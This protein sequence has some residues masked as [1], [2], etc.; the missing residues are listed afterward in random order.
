M[1]SHF[2]EFGYYRSRP[3]DVTLHYV[4]YT[5]PCS[6]NVEVS[7]CGI[8]NVNSTFVLKVNLF[9]ARMSYVSPQHGNSACYLN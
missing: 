6:T 7:V 3:N 5:H 2:Q 9:M 8:Q 1:H 4:K